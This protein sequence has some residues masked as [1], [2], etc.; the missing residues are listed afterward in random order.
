MK[1][2]ELTLE[3]GSALLPPGTLVEWNERHDEKLMSGKVLRKVPDKWSKN[4]TE[5]QYVI[6]DEHKHDR[7]ILR[8][9]LRIIALPVPA[10]EF[11][12]DEVDDDL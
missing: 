7:Y 1:Q 5:E 6:R 2:T 11:M 8:E 9:Q 3:G 10:D 4:G 12:K